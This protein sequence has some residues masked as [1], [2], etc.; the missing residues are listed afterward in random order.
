MEAIESLVE[1]PILVVVEGGITHWWADDS[2]FVVREDGIAE[3]VFAV[4]LLKDA[5]VANSLGREETEGVVLEDRDI[6]LQKLVDAVLKVAE[7]DNA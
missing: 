4:A 6:S 5:L 2:H 1:Q 3:G 7:D